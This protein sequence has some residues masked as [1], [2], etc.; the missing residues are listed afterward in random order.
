MPT[1]PWK[2][3]VSGGKSV[4]RRGSLWSLPSLSTS[5]VVVQRPSEALD[6]IDAALIGQS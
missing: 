5:L 4:P 1:M 3:W 2:T 6:Y